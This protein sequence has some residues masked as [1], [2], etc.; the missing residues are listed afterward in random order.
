MAFIEHRVTGVIKCP[1]APS[2]IAILSMMVT[3]TLND[4]TSFYMMAATG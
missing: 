2:Y 4:E 1:Y 3:L